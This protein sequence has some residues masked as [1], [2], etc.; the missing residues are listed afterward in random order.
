[1]L[2]AEGDIGQDGK[3]KSCPDP[4]QSKTLRM[5][6]NSLHGNRDT[7][8]TPIGKRPA[9]RSEKAIGRTSDM[10]VRGE[11]DGSIVPEN[12]PNK[13]GGRWLDRSHPKAQPAERGEGREPIKGNVHQTAAPRTQSRAVAS[14]GL[15]GVRRR[16]L[17]RQAPEI[18]AVCG[19]AARTDPR[20]G[21]PAR[22]VPTATRAAAYPKFQSLDNC[23]AMTSKDW[24]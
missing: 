23:G 24:N 18:R 9:G 11:S 10:H 19:N 21:P 20:G 5:R 16:A 22:A 3:G 15:A 2:D 1:L 7:P 17:L 8:R 6:G 14:N 4:A 13:G 12:L